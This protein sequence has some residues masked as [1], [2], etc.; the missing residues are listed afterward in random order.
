LQ[1]EGKFHQEEGYAYY[2]TT[3]A[4]ALPGE[5]DPLVNMPME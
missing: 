4:N 3:T 2:M 1:V 5:S